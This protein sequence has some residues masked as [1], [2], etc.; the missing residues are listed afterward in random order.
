MSTIK[1]QAT[2]KKVHVLTRADLDD[3]DLTQYTN[4]IFGTVDENDSVSVY[5]ETLDFGDSS[6]SVIDETLEM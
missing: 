3:L 1:E 5:D 6:Y 2:L 4:Q